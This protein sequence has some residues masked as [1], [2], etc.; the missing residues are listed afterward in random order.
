M[1]INFP[2]QGPPKF[3]QIRIFGF[4]NIP[5]GNPAQELATTS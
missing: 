3:I 1:D 2:I 4:E 5:S